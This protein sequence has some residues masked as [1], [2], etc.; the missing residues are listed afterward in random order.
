MTFKTGVCKPRSPQ[1]CPK[2][3]DF[4]ATGRRSH[5]LSDLK[6]FVIAAQ[7]GLD[8]WN[9]LSE[10]RAHLLL[11]GVLWQSRSRTE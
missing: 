10:V 9:Q 5:R 7:G 8:R 4:A 3:V 6:D 1:L 11:G 2:E